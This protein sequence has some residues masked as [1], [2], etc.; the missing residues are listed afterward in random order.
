MFGGSPESIERK[1]K[2]LNAIRAEYEADLQDL[3]RQLKND[4]ITREKYERL[5][6]LTQEKVDHLISQVKKLRSKREKVE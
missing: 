6:A 5:S 2:R 1:I 3:K 4:K